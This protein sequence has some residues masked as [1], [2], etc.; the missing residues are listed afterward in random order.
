MVEL[1]DS[2]KNL[3][4]VFEYMEHD[5]AGL[6]ASSEIK[7]TEAQKDDLHVVKSETIV[8]SLSQDAIAFNS[9]VALVK[10]YMKQL[11]SGIEHCHSQ[12]VLHCDIKGSNLVI[13]NEGVLKIADLGLVSFYD[14]DQRYPMT[15]RVVTQ[16][17]HTTTPLSSYWAPLFMM[18]A[19]TS[20]VLDAFWVSCLLGSPSC[21]DGRSYCKS[22]TF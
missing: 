12:G 18:L 2:W 20:G 22:T 17:Y 7:F 16:W 9:Q 4:L 1:L 3:I 15:T 5:I 19:L 13:D 21:Q 14:P 10:C 8:L 6:V 11:L